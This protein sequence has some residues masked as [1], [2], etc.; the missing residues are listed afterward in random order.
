M[1]KKQ[2]DAEYNEHAQFNLTRLIR[3]NY[4]AGTP[5]PKEYF[6][7]LNFLE[8]SNKAILLPANTP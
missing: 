1:N 4:E 6:D 2:I 5:L 3:I 8:E 7:G